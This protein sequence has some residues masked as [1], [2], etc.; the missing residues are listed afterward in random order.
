VRRSGM[1]SH[2]E[3]SRNTI[4][5]MSPP[6]FG[7]SSGNSSPTRAKRVARAGRGAGHSILSCSNSFHVRA[8]S[9]LTAALP[10]IAKLLYL[11]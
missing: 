7:H 6:Q 3:S 5:R 9:W 1:V 8:K 11:E 4:S 2:S 10:A